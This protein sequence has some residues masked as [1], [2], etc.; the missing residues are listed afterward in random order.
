MSWRLDRRDGAIDFGVARD[1]ARMV[2]I[3]GIRF[4][5]PRGLKRPWRCKCG[6]RD[7]AARKGRHVCGR[8]L[9]FDE[10][11]VRFC[12]MPAAW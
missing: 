6:C 5:V 1:R 11:E 3:H 4:L 2:A 10:G 9:E 7:V 8:L 12:G